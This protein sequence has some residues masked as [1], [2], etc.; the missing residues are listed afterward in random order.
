MVV[1][2]VEGDYG[3]LMKEPV[4]KKQYRT[5]VRGHCFSLI[6]PWEEIVKCLDGMMSDAAL[7]ALP[8]APEY[9]KYLVRLQVK[10][11]GKD[12]EQHLKEVKLRPF[13]LVK[14]LTE[15]VDRH[16]GPFADSAVADAFRNRI[17]AAV[18]SKYPETEPD[19]ADHLKQ[20]TIPAAI[21]EVIQNDRK[22]REEAEGICG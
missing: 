8:W 11:A 3:H 15:L 21:L 9:L 17:A 5:A 10:V 2:Y 22:Q 19:V 4:A 1:Y 18:A 20:G 6:M 7:A 12:M 16:H 13:I 14:L